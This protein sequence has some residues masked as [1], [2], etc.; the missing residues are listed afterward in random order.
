MIKLLDYK[1]IIHK[2]YYAIMTYKILFKFIFKKI[3]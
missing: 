2:L 3:K 1:K